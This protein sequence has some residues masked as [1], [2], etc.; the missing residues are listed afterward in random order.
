M[1]NTTRPVPSKRIEFASGTVAVFGISVLKADRPQAIKPSSKN[2]QAKYKKTTC[3]LAG[4]VQG[5]Y[6]EIMR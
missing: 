3:R 5:R 6:T 4:I 2:G 1:P